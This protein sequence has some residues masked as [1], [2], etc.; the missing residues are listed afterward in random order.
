MATAFGKKPLPKTYDGKS[1]TL[2]SGGRAA[3]LKDQGV[4]DNVI[5]AIA[6]SKGA[7]PGQKFYHPSKGK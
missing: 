6:R 4:P 7:A 5:G 2:G 3:K 1:T